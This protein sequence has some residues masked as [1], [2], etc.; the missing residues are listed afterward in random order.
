MKIPLKKLNCGFSMPVFGIGT[1]Q[2]GGRYEQDLD[3]DD[4]RDIQAIRNAIESGLTHIDTAERYAGGHTEE[5]VGQAISGYP[6]KKLLLASKVWKTNLKYEDLLQACIDSLKRLGTDY[7]DLYLVHMPN[8]DIP[9]IETMKAMSKLKKEGMI[10]NI[11]LSDFTVERFQEAQAGCA[12]KIVLNQLHYNLIFREPERKNLVTFCRDNDVILAAWRPVQ[13]G[14]LTDRSIPLL[15][16]MC[17]KYHKTPAQIAINWLISQ[18]NIIT[19]SKMRQN[20]HLKENLGALGWSMR[21]DDIQKLRTEFPGQR[22]VSDSVPL[23]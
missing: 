19:L 7:L 5:I 4:R 18:K 9:I 13:Y 21:D 15:G 22:D 17:A 20:A 23:I 8:P 14:A 16:Q 2:M 11:G 1:W 12:D 3:N 6:R 10:R